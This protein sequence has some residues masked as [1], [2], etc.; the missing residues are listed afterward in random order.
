MFAISENATLESYFQGTRVFE[1]AYG[2]QKGRIFFHGENFTGGAVTSLKTVHDHV[3][4]AL[5][6]VEQV[7]AS[8]ETAQQSLLARTTLYSQELARQLATV[9]GLR[10]DA[11]TPLYT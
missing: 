8:P 10:F 4:M 1:F 11:Y 3:R 7:M 6:N 5:V 9:A 2:D